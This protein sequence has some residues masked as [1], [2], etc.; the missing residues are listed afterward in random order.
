VAGL[1][2]HAFQDPAVQLV[3]AETFPHLTASI[4][5]LLR[6]HFHLNAE[7]RRGGTLRYERRRARHGEAC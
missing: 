6:N 2:D 1:V 5:V 7:P 4:G 3:M